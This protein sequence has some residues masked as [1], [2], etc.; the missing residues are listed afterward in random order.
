[1]KAFGYQSFGKPDVFEE[2]EVDQPKI[3]GQNQVIVETLAV[4]INNFERI[5]RMGVIGGDHFPVIPGRDIVGRVVAKSDDV[6]TIQLD[7]VIIGHAGPAYAQFAK[8]SVNRLIKKPQNVSLEQAAA[9]ITPGIT[10]YNAVTEFTHVRAGDRVL[11]NGA[12]GGVGMIAA[13]VAKHLGAYVVGVGSSKNR[14]TLQSLAPDQLAFYDQEDINEK[15]ADQ[16][17]VVINAA[18]NG[19]N[20]ALISAVIRDGGRAASVGEANNLQDKPQVLFEHIRPLDAQHDRIALQKLATMLSDK[21]LQ[22]PIFKTLPLT[23]QGVVKGHD[24]LE[25]RHAPGRIILMK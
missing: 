15:F 24:L 22:V 9:I 10:A 2:L 25:Q 5:Q 4:G 13:Q 8:L 12:T 1:M 3:T 11:V 17:D 21:T 20:E 14:T 7:D 16:F 23:L 18:M 19:N 6:T